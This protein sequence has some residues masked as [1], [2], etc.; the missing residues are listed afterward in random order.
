MLMAFC[1]W[2]AEK[3]LWMWSN[4]V[5]QS[6]SA[7]LLIT[8]LFQVDASGTSYTTG[9]GFAVSKEA[10]NNIEIQVLP[11]IVSR[12]ILGDWGVW[13]KKENQH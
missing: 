13:R 5:L 6:L 11:S 3:K 4:L 7:F 1:L 8:R 10:L 2:A 12:K 9:Q